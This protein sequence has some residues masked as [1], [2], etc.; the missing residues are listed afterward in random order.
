MRKLTPL[1]KLIQLKANYTNA[2]IMQTLGTALKFGNC[3]GLAMKLL[4]TRHGVHNFTTPK[5][6]DIPSA[7]PDAVL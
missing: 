6:I 2:A 7:L 3:Y 4:L 1:T 5:C